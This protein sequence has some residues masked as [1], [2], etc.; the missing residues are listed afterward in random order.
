MTLVDHILNVVLL[1]KNAQ[2]TKHLLKK[3]LKRKE[4]G[5]NEIKEFIVK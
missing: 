1:V 3:F 4:R 2:K 5:W